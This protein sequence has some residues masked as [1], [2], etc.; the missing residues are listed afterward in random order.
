[1]TIIGAPGL[2]WIEA[3]GGLVHKPNVFMDL[4]G[5]SPNYFDGLIITAT[6]A[7]RPRRCSAPTTR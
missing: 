7:S 4:S 6:P 5:W 3:A 2:A 1:M